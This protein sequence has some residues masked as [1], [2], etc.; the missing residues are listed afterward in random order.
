M[1]RRTVCWLLVCMATGILLLSGRASA[2]SEE[3]KPSETRP[4]GAAPLRLELV[5]QD[6]PI[7]KEF[8]LIANARTLGREAQ[9][10]PCERAGLLRVL[11]TPI[12][13]TEEQQVNPEERARRLRQGQWIRVA[14]GFLAV[15][16]TE[17]AKA[18]KEQLLQFPDSPRMKYRLRRVNEALTPG[19]V[20][21]GLIET[22]FRKLEVGDRVERGQL[23]GL[24]DP[25]LALD[26][27]EIKVSKLDSADADRMASEKTCDEARKRL[28]TIQKTI[29]LAPRAVSEDE[30]RAAEL[31]EQRYVYE[32]TAKRQ[33]VKQAECEL[34]TALTIL[35]SHEIR[36]GISGVVAKIHHDRGAGVKALEPIVQI[37][38][39]DRL[40]IEGACDAQ[41]ARRLKPGM[42]ALVEAPLSQLPTR[43]LRGHLGPVTRLAITRGPHPII[44]SAGEDRCL[45]GWDGETGRELFRL[46]HRAEI[47]ALACTE[48]SAPANLVLVGAADGSAQVFDPEKVKDGLVEL[49]PASKRCITAAA[50]SPDG[51][52]CAL[53]C[54]DDTITFWKIERT[55]NSIH[56]ERLAHVRWSVYISA[57]LQFI[58][59]DRLL[60]VSGNGTA[61]V[62][63]IK[64]KEITVEDH[65]VVDVQSSLVGAD[66]QRI[67]LKQCKELHLR[68][69]KDPLQNQGWL[70]LDFEAITPPLALFAPDGQ[71]ILAGGSAEGQLRLFRA[72][73]ATN[74]GIELMRL[75][76]NGSIG[77]VAFSSESR[78]VAAGTED[79]RVLVWKLPGKEEM[80]SPLSA[81]IIAITP[82]ADAHSTQ[83]SVR[84]E[85]EN[86]TGR[87]TPGRTVNLLVPE[88]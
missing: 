10:L 6:A 63:R 53:A 83:V 3:K 29:R 66:S 72:P 48:A 86:K 45:R 12:S 87:L 50:F 32:V 33:S 28:D 82:P 37:Q 36:A 16:E 27:V 24:V 85:V 1:K 13:K 59:P 2:G 23:L 70:P 22:T 52:L 21:L 25:R 46:R 34:N 74:P 51:S 78:L 4:P 30:V 38:N 5:P 11:G 15:E 77:S 81:R 40:L 69:L 71:T 7:G 65:P 58:G 18:E 41:S 43:V 67:L 84:A 60:A 79:H 31:T 76:G 56:V 14:L 19:K 42:K 17:P 75:V 64:A 35:R 73:T 57:R 49:K 68:T 20:R 8:V 47:R 39:T 55:E 9:D 61:Q 26:D 62:W 80:T 88:E 54:L 44:L